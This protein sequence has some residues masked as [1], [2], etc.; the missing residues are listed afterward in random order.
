MIDVESAMIPESNRKKKEQNALAKALL[1]WLTM[2]RMGE[3][4]DKKLTKHLS[5][6][7]DRGFLYA[8]NDHEWC[9]FMLYAVATLLRDGILNLE[10]YQGDE[11]KFIVDF[12]LVEMLAKQEAFGAE[13]Y[14]QFE[15]SGA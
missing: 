13:F 7:I 10:H 4:I 9:R 1:S 11:R 2:V 14:D 8:Q 15:D 3:P 12:L 5:R 6:L